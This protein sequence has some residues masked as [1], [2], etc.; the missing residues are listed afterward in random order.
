MSVRYAYSPSNSLQ[1]IYESRCL[2]VEET[3]DQLLTSLVYR[4]V[5]CRGPIFTRARVRYYESTRS[6]EESYSR[7]KT[8]TKAIFTTVAR[9]SVSTSY[10]VVFYST[11]TRSDSFVLFISSFYFSIAR[12]PLNEQRK[13]ASFFIYYRPMEMPSYPF[14]QNFL[15]PRFIKYLLR[16]I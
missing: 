4:G 1:I 3:D 7:C 2:L 5:L 15:T 16:H 14:L 6:V 12:Y 13:E 8:D 11:L 9:Y 10:A